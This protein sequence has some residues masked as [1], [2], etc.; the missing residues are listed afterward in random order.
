M[1]YSV[2]LMFLMDSIYESP[3][4]NRCMQNLEPFTS[5]DLHFKL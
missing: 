1:A 4:H 2:I 5:S 3:H